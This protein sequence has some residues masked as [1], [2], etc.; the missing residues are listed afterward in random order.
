MLFTPRSKHIIQSTLGSILQRAAQAA[1]V[2]A[3]LVTLNVPLALL[4]TSTS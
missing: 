4:N 2:I 1:T 3:A